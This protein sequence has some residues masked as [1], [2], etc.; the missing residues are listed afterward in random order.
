MRHFVVN[1]ALKQVRNPHAPFTGVLY[2]DQVIDPVLSRAPRGLQEWRLVFAMVREFDLHPKI[3]DFTERV[4][5]ELIK[6]ADF[7]DGSNIRPGWKRL[8]KA[9][10]VSRRTIAYHL[11]YLRE[12]GLLMLVFRGTRLPRSEG[13]DCLASVYA[14]RIPAALRKRADALTPEQRMTRAGREAPRRI[15]ARHVRAP[16]WK[17]SQKSAPRRR[18]TQDANIRPSTEAVDNQPSTKIV[19]TPPGV[20]F[21]NSRNSRNGVFPSQR[22]NPAVMVVEVN[23]L[24]GHV[25]S[26]YPQFG[27]INPKL[28]ETLTRP[29]YQAGWT[30]DDVDVWLGRNRVPAWYA[31]AE[32]WPT[33]PL[34]PLLPLPEQ[35]R[36]P[37][38]LLVHRLCSLDPRAWTP[39]AEVRQRV[40]EASRAAAYQART[41]DDLALDREIAE[42]LAAAAENDDLRPLAGAQG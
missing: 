37:A 5:E 27:Q 16:G 22:V 11:R 31:E 13:G 19:C 1:P 42:L 28:V 6:V 21:R 24:A 17:P 9:L 29:L 23:P 15:G 38:G 20:Y 3:N 7:H 40:A 41:D 4:V 12:A 33:G 18:E 39:L 30:T 25:L 2:P 36:N 35:P 14:A 26:T 10:G 8:M 34:N 32:D